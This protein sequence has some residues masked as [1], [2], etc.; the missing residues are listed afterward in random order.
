MKLFELKTH[1][2]DFNMK[3][4]VCCCNSLMNKLREK[5]KDG[6]ARWVTLSLEIS[7]ELDKEQAFALLKKIS[8]ADICEEN[9]GWDYKITIEKVKK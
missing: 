7:P 1:E 8:D 6:A 9:A 4:V 3:G 5:P 2:I